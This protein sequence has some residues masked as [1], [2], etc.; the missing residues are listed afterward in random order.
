M[1]MITSWT[2]K[3]SSYHHPFEWFKA[4]YS[5]SPTIKGAYLLYNQTEANSSASTY[6]VQATTVMGELFNPFSYST[7]ALIY[8]QILPST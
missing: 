5:F 6:C 4:S 3:G 7:M 8:L 1:K 2:S